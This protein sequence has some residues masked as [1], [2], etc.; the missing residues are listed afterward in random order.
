MS[1]KTLRPYQV[2]AVDWIT[3]RQRGMVVAPAGSGKTIIAA[4]AAARVL[5]PGQRALWVANTREQVDQA[6]RAIQSTEG[7]EG[8]EWG[9][10][11]VAAR[12]DTRQ[13]DLLIVDEAH[14]APADTWSQLLNDLPSTATVWGFTATP[15]H[16][17]DENR[18]QSVRDTFKEFFQIS[19]DEVMDG[20]HLVPGIVRIID[21]DTHEEYEEEIAP[22]V[23]QEARRRAA[24]F[25]S[26]P[27]SEHQKRAA[28][29]LTQ[30]HL[31]T[32]NRRNGAVVSIAHSEMEQGSVCIILVSS[33]EHGERL[34]SL[35]EGAAVLHSKLPAKVRRERVAALR[36]GQLKCAIAT[37]LMDEGAD[38]PVASVLI[39]AAGGRSSTKTIQ[40]AGR[41]MRPHAD[42]TCGI[43]YDFA[44]RG[45]RFAH[46]QHRAR[47]R[48]YRELNY[49]I[50]K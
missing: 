22:L 48:V 13:V 29:Q 8:V 19:R 16:D 14:H 30:E 15:W 25:R 36:S 35:I 37:S 10:D 23:N 42:K 7:A 4:H 17:T 47:V 20:G 45:L 38:F 50:E 27:F 26:V 49:T 11:C 21:L 44:D 6:V 18:N 3:P 1:T 5:R 43:I 39:L 12:P 33:I 34:E 2:A 46:A 41:V 32:D 24:R 9:V 40:R 28:W 31:Q